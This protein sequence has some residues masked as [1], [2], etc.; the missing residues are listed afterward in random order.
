MY[1]NFKSEVYKLNY[2]IQKKH[3]G[4]EVIFY[5]KTLSKIISSGKQSI[6]NF[7]DK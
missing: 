7:C 4:E 1:R 3:K 2:S 6:Y 5:S